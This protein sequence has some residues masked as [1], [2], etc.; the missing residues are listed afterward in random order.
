[1]RLLP[2]TN[3]LSYLLKR[4]QHVVDR[5]EEA[6]EKGAE[7]LLSSVANYE[8]TRYLDLKGARKL[9]QAYESITV[10]W[11]RCNLDFE[12]W[13]EAASL[14]ARRHRSGRSISD[15]DLLLA[16]LARREGAVLVTSNVRHFQDLGVELEDWMAP[17]GSR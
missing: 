8:L 13:N 10:S 7:F 15:F 11:R 3:T 16:I 12:D 4:R 5:F 14:W 9:M 2:D 6:T 1:M 17:I